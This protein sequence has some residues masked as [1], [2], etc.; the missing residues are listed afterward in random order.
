ME[1]IDHGTDVRKKCLLKPGFHPFTVNSTTQETKRL[2][3]SV[4]IFITNRFVL[5]E[6]WSLSRSKLA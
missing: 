4:V 3:A 6:N 1:G 5:A 2:C